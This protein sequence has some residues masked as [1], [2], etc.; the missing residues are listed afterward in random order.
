MEAV[1]AAA[2]GSKAWWSP[3]TLPFTTTQLYFLEYETLVAT[4]VVWRSPSWSAQGS[5][6]RSSAAPAHGMAAGVWAA[7]FAG[8]LCSLRAH[9][10]KER[11]ARTLLSQRS[12]PSPRQARGTFS[13]SVD[14]QRPRPFRGGW[15]R[16]PLGEL[17]GPEETLQR[18]LEAGPP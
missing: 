2:A 15:G 12:P 18:P 16:H 9:R 17:Q 1:A 10:A 13:Q 7:G 14:H 5:G 3:P 11:S 4:A 8:G 6:V